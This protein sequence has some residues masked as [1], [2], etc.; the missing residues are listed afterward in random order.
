MTERIIPI[1]DIG[2]A[3][4]ALGRQ[5][6]NET[7][8]IVFDVSAWLAQYPAGTIAGYAMPPEG[9][10]YPI[11]LTTRDGMA[12]WTIRAGDTAQVGRGRVQIVLLGADGE[13]LHSAVGNTM[14]MP[15]IAWEAGS[16]PPE[17]IEPWT[18]Q[19]ALAVHRI[20]GMTVSAQ[21]GDTA[22]ATVSEQG[23]VKH[24]AF[25]LPRGEK[26]N[27]GDAF[28]YADFTA[29]QLAALKGEPG[30][31]A[32]VTAENI[33]AAL[34]YTP[35]NTAD[36]T[37]LNDDLDSKFAVKEGVN[38]WNPETTVIGQ[39]R[40]N[41]VVNTAATDYVATDFIPYKAGEQIWVCFY[42]TDTKEIVLVTPQISNGSSLVLY[43]KNRNFLQYVGA[44]TLLSIG[45]GY[46]I[47]NTDCAYIRFGFSYAHWSN[48][49]RIYCLSRG[50]IENVE[51]FE[52][53]YAPIVSLK[54]VT[55][56]SNPTKVSELENDAGYAKKAEFPTKVSEL[57]NDVGYIT[58]TEQANT[59]IVSCRGDSLTD[60]SGAT[61]G[62][63][64][65]KILQDLLGGDYTVNNFGIGGDGTKGI[66]W[67]FG[68]TP[69]YLAPCTIPESGSV[70]CKI[71]DASGADVTFLLRGGMIPSNPSLSK[72]NVNPVI[73]AGIEGVLAR[74]STTA[75]AYTFT[76]NE[77]GSSVT[78]DRPTFI[79]TYG[80]RNNTK[81]I[82]IFWCGTNDTQSWKGYT[83]IINYL[84]Q[85]I[86]LLPH[87]KYI[88]CGLTCLNMHSDI[89]TKNEQL[90]LAF[91]RHFLD[92]RYY[93]L[94]Y[95]LADAGITPTEE[96]EAAIASGE[97]PP[98]LLY[99]NVHFNSDG[100]A[101]IA[102]R[103]YKK[104][105]ELGY[106]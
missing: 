52:E 10:G 23:G 54:N 66:A 40:S 13:R 64:Y 65:P 25:V 68:A 45:R 5:G 43:D 50:D 106:W 16:E 77:S 76:R 57:E 53:Y 58:N 14:V 99:D 1:Q 88:V 37:R 39:L 9:E 41:G 78:L 74:S 86:D 100:Y 33:D 51:D 36:V 8:A 71:V 96:D 28:T 38:L 72:F 47:E 67:R 20:D 87:K 11:A 44:S 97:M 48:A 75:N 21:D 83:Y 19:L 98:S 91:G 12:A 105:I 92:L 103:V 4:I 79:S 7:R 30:S 34:G 101:V 85:M 26:G 42:R 80:Y 61:N 102:N 93:L 27:K 70:E 59:H 56:P 69:I 46:T 94:N 82:T 84:K 55:D 31:D 62:N 15:S 22:Q 32:N 49:V 3:V 24:I 90:S 18:N 17:A 60:G 63:T 29:E 104:G 6:D 81:D 35:A 73:I 95:G 89:A 2:R